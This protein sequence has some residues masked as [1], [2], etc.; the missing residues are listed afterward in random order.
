MK[1]SHLWTIF[2]FIINI[3]SMQTV[4]FGAKIQ[5]LFLLI[6]YNQIRLTSGGRL[7]G[8]QSSNFFR[9]L[10]PY[11]QR[12]LLVSVKIATRSVRVVAVWY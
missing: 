7:A 3:D 9:H 4:L 8:E 5:I 12:G 6:I 1:I 10:G 11:W 2:D